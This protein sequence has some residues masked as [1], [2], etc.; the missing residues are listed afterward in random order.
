[1]E[2]APWKMLFFGET[3]VLIDVDGGITID[4]IINH[5]FP[6][7]IS[8]AAICDGGLIATWVDHELR[9]A[10]MALLPLD[11]PLKNGVDKGTLRNNRDKIMVEG[12]SWC[13]VLDAEPLALTAKGDLVVFALWQR[14]VY[15]TKSDSTEIWRTG[16]PQTTEK[17]PKGY[18]EICSINL[19]DEVHI[20][21]RGA[22]HL[23]LNRETGKEISSITLEIEA[24]IDEVYNSEDQFLLSSKDGWVYS[25]DGKS[26]QIARL[27]RGCANHAAFDGEDWRIICWRQDI[28]LTGTSKTRQDLGVQLI[29]RENRWFV[30]DNQGN[31]SLHLE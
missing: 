25:T 5:P 17:L 14:G 18:E 11:E 16:L 6:T 15:A 1:M 2:S 21:T 7:Q 30:L 3:E 31:E 23:I 4:G 10:R 22:N 13:H 28:I 29:E 9:L 26:I 27:L 19:T 24:D 12:A 8:H 20:W